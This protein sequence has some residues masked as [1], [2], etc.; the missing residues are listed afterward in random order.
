MSYAGKYNRDLDTILVRSDGLGDTAHFQA[1]KTENPHRLFVCAVDLH[2]TPID[3]LSCEI[4]RDAPTLRL[5]PFV[6][7]P[8]DSDLRFFTDIT[9]GAINTFES[10][11]VTV[12]TPH[13]AGVAAVSVAIYFDDPAPPVDPGGPDQPVN[14]LEALLGGEPRYLEVMVGGEP[15]YLEIAKQ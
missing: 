2:G 8:D 4:T 11:E 6:K 13:G 15:Q 7:V 14:G 5:T 3:I 10:F 9:R 12:T 1:Q